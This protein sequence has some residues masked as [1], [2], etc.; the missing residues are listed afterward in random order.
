MT[1]SVED[2]KI[3]RESGFLES[4]VLR[5]SESKTPEGVDQPPIDISTPVWQAMLRSR[6]EWVED[7]IAK[8]WDKGEVTSEL[9]AY[10]KRDESRSPWD[11]LKAEY[12]P[13]KRVDYWGIVRKRKQGD[14]RT[15]LGEYP[16]QGE[17][18]DVQNTQQTI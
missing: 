9:R 6:R 4:E 10:Y 14:I 3:L 7:K 18:L 12:R 2:A 5:F 15:G 8:G 11:F 16:I 1:I 17:G 13:A